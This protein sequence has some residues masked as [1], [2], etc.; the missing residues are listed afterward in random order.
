MAGDRQPAEV[1]A[2]VHAMNIALGA[3]GK[4]LSYAEVAHGERPAHIDDLQRLADRIGQG[5]VET[6]LLIGVNPVYD[7]PAIG[8]SWKDLIGQVPHSMHLGLYDDE[9]AGV[10][11]WHLN[12]THFLE[13]WGTASAGMER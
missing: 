4:T 7:A 6:L 10:C 11:Q 2:L 1:H 8:K 13:E 9:T 3:V 5:E 12:Q